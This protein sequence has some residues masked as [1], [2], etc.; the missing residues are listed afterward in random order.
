MT[1][2][3]PAAF[4]LRYGAMLMP[5]RVERLGGVRF[6]VTAE[7]P[8]EAPPTGDR[9]ADLSALTAGINAVF[10]RWIRARPGEWLWLHRRWP[11]S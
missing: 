9:Q 7:A 5:I 4:A 6:R 3:A 10:D 11:D 2:S 1:T 8:V